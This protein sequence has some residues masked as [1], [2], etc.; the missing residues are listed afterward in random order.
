M[1][2]A[3]VAAAT[4]VMDVAHAGHTVAALLYVVVVVGASFLGPIPAVVAVLASFAAQNYFFTPP[5]SS[6]RIASV[7]D[8]V[9]FLVFGITAAVV[10]AAVTRVNE[11]RRRARVREL[12]AGR[13]STSWSSSCGA[14]P[15]STS[16]TTR[17]GRSRNCSA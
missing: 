12:E 11:L 7:D 14:C 9:A 3:G 17:S 10:S 2:G 16:S 1:A 4:V 15:R 8:V 6:L 5:R 13:G